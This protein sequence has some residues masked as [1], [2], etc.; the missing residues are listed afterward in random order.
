[1]WNLCCECPPT[2]RAAC[3]ALPHCPQGPCRLTWWSGFASARMRS[4]AATHPRRS[5]TVW[6]LGMC[7][8]ASWATAG[9]CPPSA[10][11]ARGRR[12]GSHAWAPRR[13]CAHASVSCACRVR[14]G[15]PIHN[16]RRGSSQPLRPPPCLGWC[17]LLCGDLPL[18][19][20]LPLV[21]PRSCLQ[22]CPPHPHSPLTQPCAFRMC[23]T[24]VLATD[25]RYVRRV[26]VSDA[27]RN[28]GIYTLKF[29]KQGQWRC[30]A[31]RGPR[32]AGGGC[33]GGGRDQSR[34]S[35]SSLA[36]LHHQRLSLL[37]CGVVW[38]WCRHTTA[39]QCVAVLCCC[40]SE[41]ARPESCMVRVAVIC[42]VVRAAWAR[43]HTQVRAR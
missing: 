14:V 18:P 25:L 32:A 24:A 16:R 38:R 7:A 17:A 2:P 6:R 33:G 37:R 31:R 13:T 4:R 21:K 35:R 34:R 22:L 1:M 43:A 36:P 8:R 42:G 41:R 23:P 26:F 3:P 9:L 39:H 5:R 15:C 10:V 29:F 19:P 30:V 27:N 40:W 12:P 28:K 11:G 20:P